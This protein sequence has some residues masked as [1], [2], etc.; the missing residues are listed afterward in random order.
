MGQ[1]VNPIIFRQAITSPK[2]SSW[3]SKNY[4]YPHLNH[5]NMEIQK[6]LNNLLKTRGIFL[7]SCTISRSFDKLVI[8][9][10]LYFSYMLSKQSKF[11][12]AKN[13]FKTLKKKYSSL[14]RIKDLKNFLDNL[15]ETDQNFSEQLTNKKIKYKF[16]LETSK[17]NFLDSSNKTVSDFPQDLS[18]EYKQRFFFFLISKER[19]KILLKKKKK[20]SVLSIVKRASLPKLIRV[21]LFKLKKLFVIRKLKYSL[22]DLQ[23][24]NTFSN[25]ESFRTKKGTNLLDLNKALCKSLQ[26]FTG[27]EKI[28]VRIHSNQL[29]FVPT[30]KV[31]YTF[32]LK[33]LFVFQRSRDLNKYFFETLETLYFVLGTFSYGNA[34]LLAKTLVYLLENTRKQIYIVRF[35]K[36]VLSIFFLKIPSSFLAVNG[37]KVLIKGRFNKRRRTKTLIIQQGQIS[38]Q[39]LK[40]PIDY[41]QTQAITMY[42]SFGIKVW[43]SKR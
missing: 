36:K 1:K 39:T 21:K 25:S 31:Y 18:L 4:T 14:N 6:F 11:T 40:T 19:K 35:I 8:D 9:L 43:L 33:E 20:M 5:Q 22:T 16:S 23:L 7:R 27:L 28:Q 17:K 12:W 3:F 42:G 34:A 30:M 26:N 24:R 2:V 15:Q 13:F 10:D 41:Y 32:L 29:S 38:L 37:I